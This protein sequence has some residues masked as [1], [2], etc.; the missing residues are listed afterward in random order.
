MSVDKVSDEYLQR[1]AKHPD[2]SMRQI[3]A[4]LIERRAAER[5]MPIES[6]PK[7]GTPFLMFRPRILQPIAVGVSIMGWESQM[8]IPGKYPWDDAT[9]WMP[10]PQPPK[11]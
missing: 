8:A 10:L 1:M 6:E 2:P 7:D 4:E 11:G 3:A 5:W 9:H